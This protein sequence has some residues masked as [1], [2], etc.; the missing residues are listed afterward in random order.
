[1]RRK[2]IQ[3][4]V[5][6][7]C[8]RVIDLP[9]GYDLAS[10]AHYGSGQY[11]LSILKGE[12]SR[13]G[14]PIP[15]LQTCDVYREWLC[16]QLAKHGIEMGKIQEAILEIDVNVQEVKLRSSYGHR[17]AEAHFF[18]D[19][20]SEIKTDEKTYVGHMAGDKEWGFN[21]FYEK[22][23]GRLPEVWPQTAPKLI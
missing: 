14:S 23:Y 19:C 1:M 16:A 7:F 8:Q 2:V 21:G 22:L 18:F 17:F 11:R 9:E 15:R 6:V 20:R 5:N 13:N 4:F 12:C 3:D 10:F